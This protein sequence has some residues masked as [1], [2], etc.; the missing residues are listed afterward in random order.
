MLSVI[1]ARMLASKSLSEAY[2]RALLFTGKVVMLS[3]ITLGIAV[4]T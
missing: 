3:G 2:D 4:A 1:L